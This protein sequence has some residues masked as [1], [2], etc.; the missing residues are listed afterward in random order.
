[1][2]DALVLLGA[3]EQVPLLEG[4]RE[5]EREEPHGGQGDERERVH[6]GV[7][8]E[9][10]EA[11]AERQARAEDA[12]GDVRGDDPGEVL[13]LPRRWA[14]VGPGPLRTDGVDA[15]ARAHAV[16]ALGAL[17]CLGNRHNGSNDRVD[18]E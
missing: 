2:H 4:P 14:A 16:G 9:V 15:P 5:P 18:E 7:P 6:A 3:H 10:P 12:R 1:M 13:A 17:K 8:V 11:G